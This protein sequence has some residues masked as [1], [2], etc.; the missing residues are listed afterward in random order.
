MAPDRGPNR[1]KAMDIDPE[2]D[3]IH[4]SSNESEGSED[5][6]SDFDTAREHYIDVEKSKLRK[7]NTTALG[8]QYRGSR[9]SR[10]ATS[11]NEEEDDPFTK[12]F[13]DVDSESDDF[14]GMNIENGVEEEDDSEVSTSEADSAAD[15]GPS[16]KAMTNGTSSSSKK[17]ALQAIANDSK[18][19]ARSTLAQSTKADAEK[20][21]AVKKQRFT[22]DSLLNARIKL[23]K[24][25]MSVNTIVGTGT[26]EHQAESKEAKDVIEAAEAAAFKLWSSLND[27]RE[28][29]ISTRTGEKRKRTT[30]SVATPTERLW[31][32]MQSQEE[33]NMPHR[34]VVLQRWS[35]KTRVASNAPERGRINQSEHQSTIVDALRETLSNRERLL[36]RVHTPRSCAPLQLANRVIQ[37]EQ[38]YDDADFYGLL[39]KELLEQKSQDSVAAANIN[40]NFNLQRE[41]KTRKIVDTKASKGRK[42]RYTVHEKLQNF[43]APEDRST[44][45]ERQTDE[46]FGSLFGQRMELGEDREADE[47][48]RDGGEDLEAGLMMFRT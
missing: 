16:L 28:E 45:G 31:D 5:E 6:Q 37:D 41:A 23:Q 25:L 18:R 32:H 38:I 39:L 7:S 10:G 19:Q 30:F 29:L 9:I 48:I 40:L 20:G 3:G 24:S 27:L 15:H 1:E 47:E 11:D 36:K 34:N 22:F 4:D 43:M 13:E 44:W 35:D 12:G 33:A 8:P 17:E 46:L 42:L 2:S 21:R 26:E 14:D